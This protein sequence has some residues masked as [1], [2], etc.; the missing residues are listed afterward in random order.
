MTW[1]IY[2]AYGYTGRLIAAEAVA[3]GHEPILA[4]RREEPLEAMADELGLDSL[5]IDLSDTEGLRDALRDVDVVVHAAGPFVHTAARMMEACLA[6]GT[7]YTDITGEI[8]VF[9]MA[10]D[11]DARARDA[12]VLLMPG[13]GF[14]VVPTDCLARYVSDQV[15]EPT[16]L[17][18]AIATFGRAS[19]GTTKSAL[20]GL[21][22]GVLERR[23]GELVVIPTASGIR[24]QRFVDREHWI[25]QIPWGDLVTAY[26]STGIPNIQTFMKFPRRQIQSLRWTGGLVRNALRVGA[27]RRLVTGLVD[28]SVDG[29]SESERK[30]GGTQAWARAV[31]AAGDSAEAWLRALEGYEF[32][33]QSSVTIVERL[34]EEATP[35]ARTPAMELGPDFVLE[36]EG[37]ERFDEV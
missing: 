23:G 2:G 7:H 30:A 8:P 27:V 32:T 11:R 14:D 31:N 18:I 21:A 35:G 29:P 12:G 26:H 37:T 16:H 20:E 3:R 15:E 22:R 4:G 17:E 36:I 1:M 5:P 33:A 25:M 24:K 10:F 34:L 19:R 28:R 6:A 9:E 13:V